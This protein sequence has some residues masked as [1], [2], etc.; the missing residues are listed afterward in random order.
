MQGEADS[1][2]QDGNLLRGIP[3]AIAGAV[4]AMLIKKQQCDMQQ[5]ERWA[6]R[7]SNK[8]KHHGRKSS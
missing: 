7:C 6:S 1:I 2:T 3:M 4:V 5:K 8:V